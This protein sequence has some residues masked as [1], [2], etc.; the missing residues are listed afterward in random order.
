MPRQSLHEPPIMP[1]K[2]TGPEIIQKEH[3]LNLNNDILIGD[4]AATKKS[5]II[6]VC[7]Q[8]IAKPKE[9]GMNEQNYGTQALDQFMDS[10]LIDFVIPNI[11]GGME[12]NINISLLLFLPQHRRKGNVKLKLLAVTRGSQFGAL[13]CSYLKYFKIRG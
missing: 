11:F 3:K 1:T 6:D 8:G 9:N 10:T 2:S 7:E 12:E 5:V 13:R 4:K